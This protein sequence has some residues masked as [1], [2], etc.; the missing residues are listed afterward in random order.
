[1]TSRGERWR[2]WIAAAAA[3]ALLI[4]A[5]TLPVG[6]WTVEALERLRGWGPLGGVAFAAL[7]A[8]ATV[9][10]LPGTPLTLGAGLL[11]G[12]WW[13]S[14][15][16]LVGATVGATGAFALGRSLLR[17]QAQRRIAG[18][19]RFHALDAAVGRDGFRVVLLVRL[20]PLF[21]FNL[22]NYAFGLTSVRLGTYALASAIGMSPAILLITGVGAGLGSLGEVAGGA[23]LGARGQV[24]GGLG[25]LATA[26]VTVWIGR[27]ARRELER[28]LDAEGPA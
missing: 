1:M 26:L 22:V 5:A 23:D 28:A 15:V 25:L 17:E 10:M 7:Y 8:I 9:A 24:L 20:S 12:P 19:P 18:W 16:V 2:V 27:A 11:Y 13:G 14:L 3:I 4:A 21:P 6:A